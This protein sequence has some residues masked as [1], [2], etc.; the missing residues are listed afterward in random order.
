MAA[1]NPEKQGEYVNIYGIVF[2]GFYP[3]GQFW[4]DF[5]SPKVYH[6]NSDVRVEMQHGGERI[7]DDYVRFRT[8]AIQYCGAAIRRFRVWILSIFPV[9]RI[10]RSA[11]R[12]SERQPNR[13]LRS[14]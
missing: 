11:T 9:C 4:G 3:E 8:A 14:L 7:N 5:G 1:S 2:S 6:Y 13:S 12:P 10:T